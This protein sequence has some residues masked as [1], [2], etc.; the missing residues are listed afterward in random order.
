MQDEQIVV[1]KADLDTLKAAI[2]EYRACAELVAVMAGATDAERGLQ[3]L[4]DK[5]QAALVEVM[6]PIPF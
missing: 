1:S 2:A 6:H 3:E 4:A 5:V